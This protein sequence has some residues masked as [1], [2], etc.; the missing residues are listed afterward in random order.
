MATLLEVTNKILKR[1]R[2][3]EVSSLSDVYANLVASFV[4]EVVQELNEAIVWTFLD[5]TVTVSVV[6]GTVSYDLSGTNDKSQL[7]F[8][9]YGQPHAWVFDDASDRYGNTMYYLDPSEY[10]RKFQQDRGITDAKPQWF[11]LEKNTDNDGLTLSL[12]P[13]P[14]A[15]KYIRIRFNTPEN[16]LDPDT[17]E[18][19]TIKMPIRLVRLGA[20]EMALNERGEEIGEPGNLTESKYQLAKAQAIEDEIRARERTG[21]YDWIRN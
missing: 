11:T 18:D 21:V 3:D 17:D 14:S 19:V 15:T 16:E 10:Q 8:D 7:L 6:A 2:E 1:L 9:P 13:T 20:L 4:A 5:H 12:W